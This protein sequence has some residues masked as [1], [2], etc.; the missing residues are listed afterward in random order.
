MIG[1]Y[2]TLLG[3]QVVT[4]L[5]GG[6][7]DRAGVRAGDSIELIDGTPTR[8]LSLYE[9]SDLLLGETGSEVTL[10]IRTG[11]KATRGVVLTRSDLVVGGEKLLQANVGLGECHPVLIKIPH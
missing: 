8:G 4:P 5:P 11:S 6:P 1:A 9:A 10:S 3:Q 7:A 2:R